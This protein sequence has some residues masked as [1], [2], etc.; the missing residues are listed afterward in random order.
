MEKALT[1]RRDLNLGL[2]LIL[3][4]PAV[5]VWLSATYFAFK[6]FSHMLR[7]TISYSNSTAAVLVPLLSSMALVGA[8]GSCIVVVM[9][10]FGKIK[11]RWQILIFLAGLILL[12]SIAG[13]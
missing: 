8:L 7:G 11:L 1:H 3:C 2:H 12:W 4:L 6:W 13:N 9:T 5:C 10:C